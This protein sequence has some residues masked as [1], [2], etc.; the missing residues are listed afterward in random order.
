MTDLANLFRLTEKQ[1]K[2][3]V[4]M[5]ARA[6]HDYPFLTYHFPDETERM[7]ILPYFFSFPI[8]LGLRLGEVYAPSPELE[9]IAVWIS[10]TK[11]HFSLSTILR[12]VPL[13]D[14]FGLG[15]YGGYKM[16]RAGD[17]IDSIHKRLAPF[18]HYFLWVLGVDPSHRGK[19]YASKL[20]KPILARLDEQRLPCYLETHDAANVP[21]YEHFGFK[22][23]DKSLVIGT[24]LVNWAML[25]E[26]RVPA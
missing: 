2:P 26:A 5:L 24:T 12:S 17:E 6:F 8:H 18:E 20:V 25:R 19:G 3:A 7:K 14:L 11:Y 15:R 16:M 23:I 13:R 4:E 10:S 1:V 9:G 22:V 21:M